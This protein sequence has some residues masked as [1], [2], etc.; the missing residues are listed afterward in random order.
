MYRIR[1]SMNQMEMTRRSQ[2]IN[3]E[4][5]IGMG[6]YERVCES[7]IVTY[8]GAHNLGEEHRFGSVQL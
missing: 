3:V 1:T 4:S 2:Y 7:G 6:P 8:G 5:M